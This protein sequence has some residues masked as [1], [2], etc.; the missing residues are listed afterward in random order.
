MGAPKSR[1]T[2][3]IGVFL[4]VGAQLLDTACIDV[5]AT[6]SIEYLSLLEGVAPSPIVSLAPSVK[7]LCE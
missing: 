1:K 7:I 2:V 4:P 6:M 5:F 3:R